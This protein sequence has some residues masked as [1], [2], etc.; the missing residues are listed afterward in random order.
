MVSALPQ[1]ESVIGI[2]TVPSLLELPS[3]C[4][5]LSQSNFSVAIY[6][7]SVM[8]P[9][10]CCS[11]DLSHPLM[12]RSGMAESYGSLILRFLGGLPYRLSPVAL[13]RT[14]GAGRTG[15]EGRGVER[16]H[17]SETPRVGVLP[18]PASI[19][20]GPHWCHREEAELLPCPPPPTHAGQ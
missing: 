19:L 13:E 18:T 1:H 8:Y 2:C 20:C 7:H 6:S 10:Q 16:W 4:P 11:L 14:E 5:G 15:M 12:P 17:G 3:H 9:L